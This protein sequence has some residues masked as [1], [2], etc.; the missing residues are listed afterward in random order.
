M[1]KNENLINAK[2][3]KRDEFFTPREAVENE[4]KYYPDCFKRESSL[5]QL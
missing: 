4:L 1:S 3:A 5:L 2:K